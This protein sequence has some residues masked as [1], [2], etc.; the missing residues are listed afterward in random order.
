[1]VVTVAVSAV[2]AVAVAAAVVPRGV[3]VLP[4]VVL[5]AEA[6]VVAGAAGP[7]VRLVSFPVSARL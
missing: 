7:V 2:G 1:M 4:A 5:P 3:V 6:V